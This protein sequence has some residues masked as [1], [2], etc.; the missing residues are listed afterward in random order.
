MLE[1]DFGEVAQ[2]FVDA[3]LNSQVVADYPGS[4]PQH[5]S[6]AYGIQD[7]A[8]RLF[9]KPVGGW[10][11]GRV[12]DSLV[13]KYGANRLAGPVFAHMIVQVADGEVA[14]MPALEGFAAVEAELMLRVG[15]IPPA[16]A[17]IASITDC[18]DEV[19]FGL[20]IASS[21]F[22]GINDH[23]PA[24]TI[25]DFGNNFGLV[26]GPKIQDWQSRDLLNAPVELDVDGERIGT[27]KLANML[28]G[29]FGAAAFLANLLTGRGI[30]LTPGTWIS[31]GAIT[32]VHQIHPGQ[33]AHARFDGEF[34]VACDTRLFEPGNTA[35]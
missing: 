7:D 14:Q 3:R 24:V 8:I 22:P 25:S 30:E 35:G 2:T 13:E 17:D 16:N 4:L 18:I 23:G 9:A 11:V 29:P 21:P 20:E 26:L 10:K 15:K 33:S 12:G 31:T 1:T 28:D 27:G 5:F 6:E 34:E 32:G 19:R